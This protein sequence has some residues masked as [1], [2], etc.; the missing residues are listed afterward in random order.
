[1]GRQENKIATFIHIMSNS[2]ET[3][4]CQDKKMS[5]VKIGW[6]TNLRTTNNPISFFTDEIG[7]PTRVIPRAK[8][9][10]GAAAPANISNKR[11]GV[12]GILISRVNAENPNN[13]DNSSGFRTIERITF[14]KD[15]SR[16]LEFD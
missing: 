10:V 12:L 6:I 9:A 5:A 14:F 13:T 16:E 7:C 11:V 4:F 3:N 2:L 8:S 15:F 1:M